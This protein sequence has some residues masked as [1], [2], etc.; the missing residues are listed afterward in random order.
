MTGAQSLAF[1]SWHRAFEPNRR[2]M[3]PS[4]PL[5]CLFCRVALP[6]LALAWS[7]QARAD[8]W[9][10]V[11]AAG[12]IYFS[13]EPLGTSGQ[14]LVKGASME[15]QY[16]GSSNGRHDFSFLYQGIGVMYAF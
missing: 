8:L 10:H 11:D 13:A 1:T 2:L 6:A 4:F 15:R 5:P 3:K 12:A 16:Q 7:A 14:F 9:M